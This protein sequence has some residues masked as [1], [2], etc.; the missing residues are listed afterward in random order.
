MLYETLPCGGDDLAAIYAGLRAYNTTCV[1]MQ[2]REAFIPLNRKI[3]DGEGRIIAG[4]IA[5]MYFWKVAY[6]EILWVDDQHRHQGLGT[7]L[8]TAVEEAA[9]AEGCT[10]IHL[11]TFD[12]Q[13]RGFYERL[14]Y[15]VFGTLEDCPEG[16][17]RYFMKK[18][19][20]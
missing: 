1:P 2:Q 8:L 13:A 15:E 11:D 16:H 4:C 17:C 20:I 6:V 9:R 14:G 12:F 10:L 3:V 18:K 19:L 5:E 7:I